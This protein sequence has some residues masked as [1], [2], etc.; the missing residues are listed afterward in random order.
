MCVYSHNHPRFDVTSLPNM[1]F[2]YKQVHLWTDNFG[3][4]RFLLFLKNPG[5]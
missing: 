5:V 2:I 4:I 3:L 1:L